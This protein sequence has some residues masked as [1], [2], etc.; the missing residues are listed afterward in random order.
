MDFSLYFPYDK[1]MN[2]TEQNQVEDLSKLSRKELEEKYVELSAKYQCA[3]VDAHYLRECLNLLRR[4][5]FGSTSEKNKAPEIDGQV[6]ME[7][8]GV[9]NEA[10][11]ERE[12]FN[13]E[14]KFIQ[15]RS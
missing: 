14:A 15:R 2:C 1:P 3:Q 6:T 13:F 12:P 10:E 8:L 4:K 11:S 5:E 7:S 9:F